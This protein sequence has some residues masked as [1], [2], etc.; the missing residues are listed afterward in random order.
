[1]PQPTPNVSVVIPCLNEAATLAGCIREAHEGIRSAHLTGEVLVVD[2]GSTDDSVAIAEREGA[3]VVP[4]DRKGY[5]NALRTGFAAAAGDW[6]L[7][8]DADQSYDFREL[9]HFHTCIQAGA[10]LVMGSRLRGTIEPGAMPLLSRIGN[11]LLSYVLRLFF[12]ARISDAHCGLRAFTKAAL[13]RMDLRTG[14]MELASEMV[15][16]AARAGLT[17]SEIPITLRPDKRDRAPHLRPFRDGW[18]HLRFMLMM[19]PNWLFLLPGSVA[20]FV[21]ALLIGLLLPGP[22]RVGSIQL[23]VHTMLLGMALVLLGTYLVLMGMCVK[24]FTYTERISPQ[25]TRL[26]RLF[27]R[28]K[29]EH[30]LAVAT[31]LILIGLIGDIRFLLMWREHGFGNLDVQACM[32]MAILY[33]TLLTTG[34]EIFFGSFFLSML[35]ITRGDYV[36]QHDA[37]HN[38]NTTA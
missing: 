16:K 1:M 5:G 35:G 32:R 36:G 6:I 28:Y 12:H 15:I 27:S 18:R 19:A 25:G 24:V 37:D 3:R 23:D 29:L 26:T 14:G 30:G 2:N 4:C 7:M 10:D 17:L 11:P 34:I 33:T 31:V 9:P 20:L 21:G 8:G 22:L 38:P 13:D